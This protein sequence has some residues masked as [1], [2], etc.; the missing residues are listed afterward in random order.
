ME[1]SEEIFMILCVAVLMGI[2]QDLTRKSYFATYVF[3]ETPI[4]VQAWTD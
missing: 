4:F 1:S 2:V 3:V